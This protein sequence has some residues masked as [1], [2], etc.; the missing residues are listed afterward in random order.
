ML[1][2]SIYGHTFGCNVYF[3][4]DHSFLIHAVVEN[5]GELCFVKDL[6]SKNKVCTCD[7]F[8]TVSSD[9]TATVHCT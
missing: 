5:G 9:Y 7:V 4:G 6:G 8:F 1:L 3:D 2:F